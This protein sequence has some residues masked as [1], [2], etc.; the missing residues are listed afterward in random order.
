MH[1]EAQVI[2]CAPS[3]SSISNASS[4]LFA[5]E[6]LAKMKIKE[7]KV[8]F[9]ESKLKAS[10]SKKDMIA[11]LMDRIN[12]SLA[13]LGDNECEVLVGLPDESRWSMIE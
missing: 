13:R 12:S 6:E 7:L 8:L 11:S 1:D 4:P 5:S 9:A 10:G 3:N 2:S